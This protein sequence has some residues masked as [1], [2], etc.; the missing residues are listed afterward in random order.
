MNSMIGLTISIVDVFEAQVRNFLERE[1]MVVKSLRTITKSRERWTFIVHAS[2]DSQKHPIRH[3]VKCGIGRSTELAFFMEHARTPA[4]DAA[5]VRPTR[6][7]SDENFY[8]IVFPFSGEDLFKHYK[9]HQ[10]QPLP[11]QDKMLIFHKIAKCLSTMHDLGLYHRDIRW[12]NVLICEDGAVKLV[13][14][15]YV[16]SARQF[17]KA[18]ECMQGILPE[19]INQYPA[20][21]DIYSLGNI[22]VKLLFGCPITDDKMRGNLDCFRQPVA[23]LLRRLVCFNPAETYDMRSVLQLSSACI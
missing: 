13:D 5:V 16:R 23:K 4:L 8:A 18:D 22:L 19:W 9:N 17:D 7:H 21:F 6:Y 11:F 20:K 14:L 10:H 2:I 15:E 12:E 3:F 1:F